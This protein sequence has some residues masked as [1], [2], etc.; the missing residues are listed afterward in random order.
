MYTDENKKFRPKKLDLNEQEIVSITN[1]GLPVGRV[2]LA[3]GDAMM[4]PFNRLK[5]ILELI[6]HYLP[7][8]TRVSSYCL[9][10]N[11]TN[12]T[13]EQLVELQQLGLKLLYG[14]EC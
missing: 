1:S 5:Q 14:C 8:V 7:Q 11:L 6:R 4:L 9:P 13:V 2:F 3:D 10:R 12:K